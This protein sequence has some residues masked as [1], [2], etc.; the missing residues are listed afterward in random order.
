MNPSILWH[1]NIDVDRGV[2][3]ELEVW[4]WLEWDPLGVRRG[5]GGGIGENVV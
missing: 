2:I 4:G 1:W 3:A 5:G